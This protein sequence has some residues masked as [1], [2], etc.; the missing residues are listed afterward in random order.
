L[1]DVDVPVEQCTSADDCISNSAQQNVLN[2]K[3]DAHVDQLEALKT[4]RGMAKS[5]RWWK[6][7]R[8]KRSS[9]VVKVK[10]LKSSWKTKM[11]WKADT[12]QVKKFSAEIREKKK[13]QKAVRNLERCL[14]FFEKKE[15]TRFSFNFINE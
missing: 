9:E 2:A 4:G 10:P 13:A 14:L 1:M 3:S 5:G 7:V 12:E 11:K 15:R 6:V 8:T